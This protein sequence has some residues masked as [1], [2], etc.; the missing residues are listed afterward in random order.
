MG[1]VIALPGWENQKL[2]IYS[3]YEIPAEVALVKRCLSR[4]AQQG[5][6]TF[7][8]DHVFIDSK[9]QAVYSLT[10]GFNRVDYTAN[11]DLQ[12]GCSELVQCFAQTLVS[13]AGGFN[14]IYL[15]DETGETLIEV[16]TFWEDEDVGEVV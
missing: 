15:D 8:I 13:E 14:W 6:S 9:A 7:I 10:I 1:D 11:E 16:P 12:D 3:R 4:V 5:H 2:E